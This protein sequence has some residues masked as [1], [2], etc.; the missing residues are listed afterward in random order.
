MYEI[1]RAYRDEATGLIFHETGGYPHYLYRDIR[2]GLSWSVKS[3]PAYFCILGELSAKN[4]FKRYPVV[5]LCEYESKDLDDLFHKL[6]DDAVKVSCE[7]IYAD[8]AN[9]NECYREAFSAFRRETET[10]DLYLRQAPWAEN[11]QHGVNLFRE[12]SKKNA[13]EIEGAIILRQQFRRLYESVLEEKPEEEFYAINALRFVLGSFKKYGVTKGMTPQLDR[14][15]RAR[16][17]PPG[18]R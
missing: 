7:S 10:R 5:F 8:I 15:L 11:F 6:T 1:T 12:Y 4:E 13:L 17:G 9:K 16:Y 18:V 3:L 14:E 2:A